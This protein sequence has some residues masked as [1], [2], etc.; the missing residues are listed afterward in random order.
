MYPLQAAVYLNPFTDYGFKKIFGEEDSKGVLLD[1]VNTLLPERHQIV[2][3]EY[4]KNEHVGLTAFD[5]KA[6]VDICCQT[7]LGETII[8]ELQKAKQAF[9]KDRALYYASF[10]I[11]QQAKKGEWDYELQNVY[12]IGI[13]DF[14]FDEDKHKSEAE[15]NAVIRHI[16]LKDDFNTVFYDK[17]TFICLT[18]PNFTKQEHELVTHADKWLYL[19][20]N[21]AQCDDLPNVYREDPMFKQI[22]EKS[23]LAALDHDQQG[24]YRDSLKAHWDLSNSLD[25]AKAEGKA[26]GKVEGIAE[27][28]AEGIAEATLAM[29]R[30]MKNKGAE[31]QFIIDCTGL[32]PDDIAAL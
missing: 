19:F 11:I 28:K 25:K 31:L 18:M 30:T 12:M 26:E 29:A 8:I 24:Q 22:F 13:L 27:G 15:K 32:S 7:K 1:F 20:K 16:Q 17:L 6:I 10:P 14:M 4:A 2:S 23:K 3:L 21:M 9:F 5:R